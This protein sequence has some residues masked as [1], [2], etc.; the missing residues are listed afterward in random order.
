M[1]KKIVNLFKRVINICLIKVLII[2]AFKKLLLS[3]HKIKTLISQS[4][5]TRDTN[6]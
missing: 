6:N 4:S 5:T 1:A 3:Y 2:K